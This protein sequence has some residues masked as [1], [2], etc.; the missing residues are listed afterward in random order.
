MPKSN[1][2]ISTFLIVK[3]V[4]KTIKLSLI[5]FFSSYILGVMW[6]IL[7]ELQESVVDRT[8]YFKYLDLSEDDNPY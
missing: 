7:C 6:L 3:Y 4:L 5:I 1:H 8:E 2:H